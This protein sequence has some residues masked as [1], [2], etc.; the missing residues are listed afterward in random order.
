MFDP[1]V[2]ALVLAASV[3]V[4]VAGAY[5]FALD[6][7][8]KAEWAESVMDSD[9]IPRWRARL[10]GAE[11]RIGRS[12]P[13][14]AVARRLPGAGLD[15][16]PGVALL[17]ATGLV[18]GSIAAAVSFLPPWLAAVALIAAARAAA[19]LLERLRRRRQARLLAQLPDVTLA[20]AAA[21]STRSLSSAIERTA[22]R[23]QEPAASELRR[24]VGRTRIGWTL[25]EALEEMR[26]EMPDPEMGLL[27]STL[28][29]HDASGGDVVTALRGIAVAME[30][31][32]RLK[33]EVRTHLSGAIATGRLVAAMGIAMP[34]GI[35]AISDGAIRTL[36]GSTFGITVTTAAAALY[37]LGLVLI[38][39]IGKVD[40]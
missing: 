7:R 38:R 13:A 40:V 2:A 12:V 5:Q 1:A 26:R 30:E 16:S 25:A 23:V 3:L 35:D 4:L 36:T 19:A 22:E 39:R 21:G 32:R 20:L 10:A 17:A 31:R 37:A 34:F 28:I 6:R 27:T 33:R 11:R 14:K 8:E 29:V 15:V 24:V 18:A 9:G